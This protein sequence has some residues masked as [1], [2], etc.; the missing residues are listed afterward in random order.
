MGVSHPN[1][2]EGGKRECN[3]GEMTY[4]LRRGRGAKIKGSEEA[5]IKGEVPKMTPLPYSS[6]WR[7]NE[8][9]QGLPVVDNW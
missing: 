2:K 1:D 7:F 3:N 4:K 5:K 6:R 8:A 9:L